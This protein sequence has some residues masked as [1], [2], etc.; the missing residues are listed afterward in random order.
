MIK[1]VIL[2]FFWE[3]LKRA[4]ENIEVYVEWISI[5]EN[6]TDNVT[7]ITFAIG[8]QNFSERNGIVYDKKDVKLFL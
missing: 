6:I 1:T 3:V 5:L 4:I 7:L 8:Y 2:K